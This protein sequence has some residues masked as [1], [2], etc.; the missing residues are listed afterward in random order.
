RGSPPE[1]F[2]R[3]APH[4]ASPGPT[5]GATAPAPAILVSGDHPTRQHRTF[6][7]QPLPGHHQPEPVQARERRQIRGREG[8]GKHVEGFQTRRVGT[9]IIGRPRPRPRPT[10]RPSSATTYTLNCEEPLW[11]L[12]GHLVGSGL[13]AR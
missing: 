9:L 11:W 6:L 1:R 13:T 2:V 12:L 5:L 3:Q 10:R 8:S 7:L 4:H